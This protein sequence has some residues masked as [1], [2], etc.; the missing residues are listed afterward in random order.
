[1]SKK[2]DTKGGGHEQDTSLGG[3]GDVVGGGGRGLV[4]LLDKCLSTNGTSVARCVGVL[5]VLVFGLVGGVDYF[6]ASGTERLGGARRLCT[7]SDA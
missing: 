5:C 2:W 6:G 4:W 3:R 7:N 1:M